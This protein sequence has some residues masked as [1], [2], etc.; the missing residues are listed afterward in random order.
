MKHNADYQ[1]MTKNQ[2][3]TASKFY[4]LKENQSLPCHFNQNK[5]RANNNSAAVSTT[6]KDLPRVY[7]QGAYSGYGGNDI[8]D[9]TLH[10]P[11]RRT[12]ASGAV[13]RGNQGKGAGRAATSNETSIPSVKEWFQQLTLAERILCVTT[14]DPNITTS[15]NN[16]YK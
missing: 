13:G 11:G 5:D 10:G 15:I 16:M 8:A 12:L 3:V 2:I 14:V 1:R 6:P 7:N 4:T 9:A